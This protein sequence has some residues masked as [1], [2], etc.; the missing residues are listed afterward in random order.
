MPLR[1]CPALA[2][3]NERAEGREG[4]AFIHGGDG[5]FFSIGND[6]S[7]TIAWDDPRPVITL[8][9]AETAALHT[10]WGFVC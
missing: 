7:F 6:G 5:I 8:T 3:L 2:A 4:S 9:P 1:A 10:F